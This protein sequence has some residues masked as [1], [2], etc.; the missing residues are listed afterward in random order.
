MLN[1]PFYNTNERV[2]QLIAQCVGRAGRND[3][4]GVAY[5]QTYMKDS[6]S[7]ELGCAQNYKLFYEKELQNRKITANPPYFHILVMKFSSNDGGYLRNA[8]YEIHSNLQQILKN[9]LKVEK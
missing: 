6:Y 8:V 5:V 4:S 3:K 1:L 2:F 7:I 9:G